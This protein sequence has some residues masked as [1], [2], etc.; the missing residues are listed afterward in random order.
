[1]PSSHHPGHPDHLIRSCHVHY[2]VM[3]QREDGFTDGIVGERICRQGAS[4][5]GDLHLGNDNCLVCAVKT[6]G[7]S[8]QGELIFKVSGAI[9]QKPDA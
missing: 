1:M 9:S 4:F 3:E 2:E 5:A 6:F 7:S 8:I